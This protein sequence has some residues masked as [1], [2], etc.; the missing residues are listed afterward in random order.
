MPGNARVDAGA[1][2]AGSPPPVLAVAVGRV[3]APGSGDGRVDRCPL[4]R[5][6]QPATN[7]PSASTTVSVAPGTH[8]DHKAGD[9]D[10]GLGSGAGCRCRCKSLSLCRAIV[11]GLWNGGAERHL[12]AAGAAKVVQRRFSVVVHDERDEQRP[13]GDHARSSTLDYEGSS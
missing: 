11:A 9:R 1:D 10:D 3:E 13:C 5:D 2:R 8:R 6:V 4:C 12:K 7:S